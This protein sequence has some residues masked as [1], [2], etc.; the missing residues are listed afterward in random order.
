[1]TTEGHQT[2]IIEFLP[3][4]MAEVLHR[5]IFIGLLH[6][7]DT[8]EAETGEEDMDLHEDRGDL[9]QVVGVLLPPGALHT[10]GHPGPGVVLELQVV[11][12]VGIE[13]LLKSVKAEEYQ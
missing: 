11:I 1:V 2:M 7:T 9:N 8:E 10:V 3:M 13:L 12:G 4:S 6:Q 5:M